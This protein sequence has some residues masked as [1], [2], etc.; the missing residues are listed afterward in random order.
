MHQYSDSLFFQL[1]MAAAQAVEK[2]TAISRR[3]EK[4]FCYRQATRGPGKI[5]HALQ[6]QQ[7][8][9][10]NLARAPKGLPL[11]RPPLLGVNHGT[12]VVAA[13]DSVVV[14]ALTAPHPLCAQFRQSLLVCGYAGLVWNYGH[15][16]AFVQE[17][18][19]HA[20]GLVWGR[21][22][23]AVSQAS[24]VGC[25]AVEFPC[26]NSIQTNLVRRS[27]R[28]SHETAHCLWMAHRL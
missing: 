8:V 11:S 23:L 13:G 15:S 21:I 25:Q 17:S 18:R 27:M 20:L 2:V 3:W 1:L 14:S 6:D 10:Q 5:V 19:R 24:I 22:H 28:Q 9:V 26:S 7:D 4:A 12:G 16:L